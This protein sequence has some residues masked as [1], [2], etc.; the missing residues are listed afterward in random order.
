[1]EIA[2]LTY[3]TQPG[4]RLLSASETV[5]YA[6]DGADQILTASSLNWIR[7]Y[8]SQA[9]RAAHALPARIIARDSFPVDALQPKRFS[10]G[11]GWQGG[12]WEATKERGDYRFPPLAPLKSGMARR[13][14][15]LFN[16]WR[17]IRS[18]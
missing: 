17:A 10:H 15:L 16:P 2:P 5:K 18:P 4:T 7:D 12:W 13:A 9:D 1:V 3:Q 8:S 14:W 11:T 6:S